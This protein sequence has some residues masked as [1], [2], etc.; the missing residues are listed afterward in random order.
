MSPCIRELMSVATA[1]GQALQTGGW[2]ITTAESCTGGG[3]AAAITEV[4]GSSAWFDYGFVTYS[5]AAKMDL[6]GVPA[7]IFQTEG[8]V[9][10]ACVTAMTLGAMTRAQANLAIAI[11][12]IAG[13]SGGTP[14]KPVGT[15]WLAWR[16]RSTLATT[17]GDSLLQLQRVEL[18]GDRS[19]V[20]DAAVRFALERALF[21]L[22]KRN[23]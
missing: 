22:S 2:R 10:A 11:S 9:S 8:A 17:P 13:P 4:P 16:W 18:P 23:L 15:V 3:L 12:G 14:D 7:E 6:L 19:A 5:N 1:L 20:R 21:I